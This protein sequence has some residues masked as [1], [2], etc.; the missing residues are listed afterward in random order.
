MMAARLSPGTISESSSSHLP[1]RAGF[2]K[3][4]AREVAIW[5][6]EPRDDAAGD[7]I[8]GSYK[9]DRDRVRLPVEGGG[10]RRPACRDNVGLQAHQLMR[11]HSH[12]IGV[13]AEPELNRMLRPSIQPKPA[14]A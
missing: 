2:Q 7:G 4:E 14:S 11:D 5:M 12:H 8:D 13:N 1:P 6:I 3:G 9:D 10:R